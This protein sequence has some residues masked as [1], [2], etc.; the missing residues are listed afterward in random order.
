MKKA[1]CGRRFF[2]L[3]LSL[4]PLLHPTFPGVYAENL[5]V[6][7]LGYAVS[8]GSVEDD[9]EDIQV[10]SSLRHT[11]TL[12]IR[13]ELG[14]PLLLTC[15]LRYSR[16]D[17]YSQAGDTLTVS[18]DQDGRWRL[19]DL[20]DLGAGFYARWASRTDLAVGEA[21]NDTLTLKGGGNAVWKPGKGTVLDCSLQG[22]F[23]LASRADKGRQ[24]WTAG[25]GF[26]SRLGDFLLHARYRGEMRFPLAPESAVADSALHSG[27]VSLQWD[28]NRP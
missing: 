4:F 10:P 19:S 24:V 5:P 6:F 11:V 18:A 7:T 9:E 1:D 12:R 23:D 13:E 22:G 16:K 20:L 3:F 14:K 2:P 8:A 25:L 15:L 17:Y 21:A 26:E 28:P 27:T